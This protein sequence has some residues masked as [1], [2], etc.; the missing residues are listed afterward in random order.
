MPASGLQHF[1][2]QLLT[3]EVPFALPEQLLD[4]SCPFLTL[5]E[6][7]IYLYTPLPFMLPTFTSIILECCSIMQF[8]VVCSTSRVERHLNVWQSFPSKGYLISSLLLLYPSF[9][10]VWTTLHSLR[11]RM[12][13]CHVFQFFP[14]L[15]LF[16]WPLKWWPSPV[17]TQPFVA[18]WLPSP[19][20]T[21]RAQFQTVCPPNKN[22]MHAESALIKRLMMICFLELEC[23]P[24][25]WVKC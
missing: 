11:I 2:L 21:K 14:I 9:S 13:F 18:K 25:L 23:P 5:L 8:S 16:Y 10:L 15:Y 24:A 12:I 7:M 1:Q 20:L 22:K 4:P 3:I 6:S 17:P 19:N